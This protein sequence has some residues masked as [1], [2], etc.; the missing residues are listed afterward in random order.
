MAHKQ[1]E[2][3]INQHEHA[4]PSLQKL[5]EKHPEFVWKL[6]VKKYNRW[7]GEKAEIFNQNGPFHLLHGDLNTENIIIREDGQAVLIDYDDSY[8][9]YPGPE[10]F[11]CLMANYCKHSLEHQLL[12]LDT[13]RRYISKENWCYGKTTPRQS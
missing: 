8:Y 4:W 11:R 1:S 7:F 3:I 2:R 13:Y 12:F 10:L 6:P 9:G 5:L